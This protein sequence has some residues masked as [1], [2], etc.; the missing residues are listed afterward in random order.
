LGILKIVYPKLLMC[1][2][3]KMILSANAQCYFP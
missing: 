2:N 3:K 1:K